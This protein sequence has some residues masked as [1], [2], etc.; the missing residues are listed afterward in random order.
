MNSGPVVGAA[1]FVG[2]LSAP[3]LPGL[4][5]QMVPM[6]PRLEGEDELSSVLLTA[7]WSGVLLI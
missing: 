6:F 3:L 1:S 2:Q 4:S 5:N 7:L